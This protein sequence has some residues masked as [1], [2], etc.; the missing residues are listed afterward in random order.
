MRNSSA[1][2]LDPEYQ[3]ASTISPAG[4]SVLASERSQ[5]GLENSADPSSGA[6]REPTFGVAGSLY[7]ATARS[8]GRINAASVSEEEY[9]NLLGE[10]QKLLDRKLSGTISRKEEIRLQYVRWSLDRVEDA[11]HGASLEALES[12]VAKYEQFLT[13]VE[14]LKSQIETHAHGH[15]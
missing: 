1:P 2:Q 14:Q 3:D 12:A 13:E 7:A 9:K 5:T 8:A 4:P 10:R 11:R 15:R 6:W